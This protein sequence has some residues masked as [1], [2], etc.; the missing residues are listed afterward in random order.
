MHSG[1]S[2][3]TVV[4]DLVVD[5]RFSSVILDV[6]P[7]AACGDMLTITWAMCVKYWWVFVQ[8]DAVKESGWSNA[9][10]KR[11]SIETTL[12]EVPRP[13]VSQT[14]SFSGS[15]VEVALSVRVCRGEGILF[16]A[17]ASHSSL[18]KFPRVINPIRDPGEEPETLS[19]GKLRKPTQKFTWS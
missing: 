9:L 6:V 10:F 15:E 14:V 13:F 5:D 3:T 18:R 16:Y 19:W 8:V 7:S 11:S 4:R 2:A 17:S 1:L 12:H